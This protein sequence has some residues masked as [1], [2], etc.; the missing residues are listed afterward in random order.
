MRSEDELIGAL[1]TAGEHAPDDGTGLLAGVALR[2]RR[3]TRRR[4][5][6]LAAATAVVVLSV[7]IRGALLS[8][9]GAGDVATTPTSGPSAPRSAPVG[10]LWPGAVFTFAIEGPGGARRVPITGLSPTQLLIL[11]RMPRMQAEGTL[12]VYD[13]KSGSSRKVAELPRSGRFV[14]GSVAADGKHVVWQSSTGKS[15]LEIWTA[16]LAG[17]EARRVTALSG[18]R[19]DVDAISVNGDQVIWSERSGG[20]WRV[21][22]TGGAPDQITGT[23]GLH[24][25]RWP[26]A[27]DAPAGPDLGDRNQTVLVDLTLITSHEVDSLPGAK[28]VRCGPHWC[29]GRRAGGSFVQRIDGSDLRDVKGVFG[30][31]KPLSMAP[32]LNRFVPLADGVHDLATGSTGTID[33][34]TLALG[35]AGEPST[36][37]YWRKGPGSYGVLNLAAIPSAQ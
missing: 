6:V 14:I 22:L 5:R 30:R 18:G 4:L 34:R 10:E 20:V 7:G 23:D 27:S 16:P 13:S 21:P 19:S 24:L 26:W 11:S 29:L 33:A 15:A 35:A 37:L 17:G 2:R 32:L 3:R 12:E 28:G 25:L 1:R 36:V 31:P 9:E 8:G